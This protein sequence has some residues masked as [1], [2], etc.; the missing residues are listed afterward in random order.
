MKQYIKNGVI[1]TRNQ[2]VIKKD[3][4]QYINPIEDII[5]ADGWKE[6]IIP[7]PTEPNEEQK[8]NSHKNK[9]KRDIEFYYNSKDVQGIEIDD[10]YYTIDADTLNKMTFRVMAENALNINKTTLWFEGE[11]I[12]MKT[13]DALELLY[14]IQIYKGE[15]FD[16]MNNC[17]IEIDK[18]DT[19]EEIDNYDYINKRPDKIKHKKN[20]GE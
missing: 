6:H 2:I 8:I 7:E 3:G 17:I 9:L 19:I 10:K 5:L 11:K 1:K 20:K 14:Q 18:I 13:K 12:E 4:K 15:C 16:T